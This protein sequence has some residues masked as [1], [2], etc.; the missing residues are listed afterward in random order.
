[1]E[2]HILGNGLDI[3][4]NKDIGEIWNLTTDLIQRGVQGLASR[5]R[6]SIEQTRRKFGGLVMRAYNSKHYYRSYKL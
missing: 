3:K 4:T 6:E 1:M 2:H 5:T